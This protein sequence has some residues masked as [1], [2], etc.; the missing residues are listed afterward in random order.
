MHL[1]TKADTISATSEPSDLS[2]ED[3]ALIEAAKLAIASRFVPDW[4]E[5]GAALRLRDGTVVSGVHLEAYVGRIAV[6]AEAVALGR[7][8][9]EHG[10]A[11]IDTIVAVFHHTDGR[12]TVLPPCGM[13][14]ELISDYAPHASV[15]M[16]DDDGRRTKRPISELLPGKYGRG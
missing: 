11:D 14:R 1:Q 12:I 16:H 7:A 10:S 4:H 6:C 5:V 15:L 9:T 13:C 2:S 8:V 3:E